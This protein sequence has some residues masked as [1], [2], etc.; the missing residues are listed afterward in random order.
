MELGK[1]KIR[2]C[3]IED[4]GQISSLFNKF[5]YGPVTAGYPI[6]ESDIRGLFAHTEIILF[7]CLEYEEKIIG[8]MLF[9][10]YCGQKAAGPDSVWGSKFLIHPQ[11]RNGPLPGKFFSD[12][13]KQLTE[14]GYKYIDVDV[15]PTNSAALPLYKRVGFIR[16]K[17]SYIDYDGYLE[18]R[19][20]LPLI[21]NFLKTGYKVEELDDSLVESGWRSLVSAKD[22]RSF[23]SDTFDI[24]GM[25]TYQYEMKFGDDIISCW[26][27]LMTEKVAMME[28]PRFRFCS[29]ILEGQQLNVGQEV[30]LRFEYENRLDR[31]VLVTFNTHMGK[32]SLSYKNGKKRR[33][34]DPGES[35]SWEEKTIIS[36]QME[37]SSS[38][39]TSI[40]F[41]ECAFTFHYGFKATIPI[42]L[43]LNEMTS[44]NRD[45]P[46]TIDLKIKNNTSEPFQG[47]IRML[48]IDRS[49]M[50]LDD[51]VE[52][53]P[54]SID[55]HEGIL[56]P[57]KLT[58]SQH[59]ISKAEVSLY[60]S[61][62]EKIRSTEIKI[63]VLTSLSTIRFSSHDHSYL[64]NLRIRVEM[65]HKTGGL[66]V[67]E[68]TTG[69][70]LVEEAWPDLGSPFRGTVKRMTNRKLIVVEPSEVNVLIVIEIKDN[71]LNVVRK[72]LL[73]SDGLVKI[74]DFA[75]G[76]GKLLKITPWC[77]LQEAVVTIPFKAGSVKDTFVYED[78]PFL[79]NDF[80]YM[81]DQDYPSDPNAYSMPWSSFENKELAVGL[82]W[83]GEEESILYGLRW[84]PSVVFNRL[85][86]ER[87]IQ[88]PTANSLF[89]LI[90]VD[91]SLKKQSLKI[92]EKLTTTMT[93]DATHYYTVGYAGGNEV[94]RVWKS[95]GGVKEINRD[96]IGRATIQVNNPDVV[97]NG[98]SLSLLVNLDTQ[99]ASGLTG[100][101][102]MNIP[103]L[104]IH[105]MKTVEKF[106]SQ[107]PVVHSF[108]IEI[109]TDKKRIVGTITF[110][111]EAKGIV[112][113][114]HF[115]FHIVDQLAK[116][117]IER[118]EKKNIPVYSVNNGCLEFEISA[119]L[120]A[121]LTSLK[122][123]SKN[124][125]SSHFPALKSYGQ[126][127]STPAGIHPHKLTHEV[128]ID[129]GIVFHQG[130]LDTFTC[131]EI[132]S[133]EKHEKVWQ[134]V[135]CSTLDYTI[136]YLTLP[137][138]PLV[139]IDV[140]FSDNHQ[141]SKIENFALHAFWN[142]FG[143]ERQLYY[144][145]SLGEK[146]LKESKTRR[147]F[148]SNESKAVLDLGNNFYISIWG[149][150]QDLQFVM[151]EW[152]DKGFQ[153]S[154]LQ[155]LKK[156]EMKNRQFSI[157]VAVSRTLNEALK[158]IN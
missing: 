101:L 28:D 115:H 63:P 156:S 6:K 98:E 26:M 14:L 15:D 17:Q 64:E 95:L 155:R 67:I 77:T 66:R 65:N 78:F 148:H 90:N 137:N 11:F 147:N 132:K 108:P 61:N 70:Q 41:G 130:D 91:D 69:K 47:Y 60:N 1:V 16:N 143:K 9:S 23:D 93:P 117:K 121:S 83:E 37:D 42:E 27:D 119:D 7:L 13:I 154:F 58:C 34:L 109:E 152:P 51:A 150:E 138:T 113:S 157:Y 151:S 73:G 120:Q 38:L 2:K 19:S 100:Q 40:R 81:R 33:L 8:T 21:I 129:K 31:R 57:L 124:L 55:G 4:A 43:S 62:R 105:E 72:C 122:Y 145:N 125:V 96:Y 111:N 49:V 3:L 84:M 139:K 59:G 131:S 86:Q 112:I 68:R 45:R 116:V 54:I 46:A 52:F 30:T 87:T 39:Q 110:T 106:T 53:N 149:N 24:N 135:R 85:S 136:D 128:N 74:E 71:Q 97:M 80:E 114:K 76:E 50:R 5:G 123:E 107:H 104:H 103:D 79:T 133:T 144:W 44:I 92:A 102:E 48:P 56:L 36:S 89:G 32:T 10:K 99:H 94:E 82:I 25:E 88:T 141:I 158:Y 18:L 134:G 127:T 22:I 20:Y 140:T 29:Y 75:L 146:T 12:S 142:K 153:L 118:T 35:I 126:N